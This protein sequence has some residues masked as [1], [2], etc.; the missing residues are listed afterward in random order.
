MAGSARA[1]RLVSSIALVA[2]TFSAAR[3]TTYIGSDADAG[4]SNDSFDAALQAD[5]GD[6]PRKDAG[7]DGSASSSDA[8]LDVDA[9][10]SYDAGD[11]A[12]IS[13]GSCTVGL[14]QVGE[15]AT[16]SGKVNVH[17][18]T[19]GAWSVDSDCSSGA[20][21]NTVTY[22]QKFWPG[23]TTQV[24]LMTVTPEQK[25]FTQGG[26]TA[27]TCGGLA[28]FQGLDQFACCAP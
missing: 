22:C 19:G 18:S 17:R 1:P 13:Q 5:A 25:P 6:G 7:A 8:A 16:W 15:Y 23:A 14:K 26:G 28:M 20:N 10:A 27:P 3:C 12:V 2:L 4:V 21:I 11:A 9:R 24:H